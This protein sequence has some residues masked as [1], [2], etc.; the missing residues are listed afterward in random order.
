MIPPTGSRES[1]R[2][3]TQA[4]VTADILHALRAL[5][6]LHN[7]SHLKSSATFQEHPRD[8]SFDQ[9]EHLEGHF[10]TLASFKHRKS[11]S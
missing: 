3:R 6:T 5:R 11:L 1:G 7:V 9:N 8:L 10:Q 2:S 4:F